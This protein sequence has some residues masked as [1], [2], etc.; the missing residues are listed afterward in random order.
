MGV[1]LRIISL[2][3]T[4]FLEGVLGMNFWQFHECAEGPEAC[5][6]SLYCQLLVEIKVFFVI[7]FGACGNK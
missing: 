2:L 7:G 3:T 5:G 4:I 6:R 1:H